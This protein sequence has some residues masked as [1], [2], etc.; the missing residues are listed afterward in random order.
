MRPPLPAGASPRTL[1]HVPASSAPPTPPPSPSLDALERLLPPDVRAAR[2]WR[3][4]AAEPVWRGVVWGRLGR[5]D[6]AWQ[7]FDRVNLPALQPWI[8]AERGR[9]LRELGLH[10][11]AEALEW[12]ALLAATDPVDDAML[13]ISLAADAVGMGDAERARRRLAAARESLANLAGASDPLVTARLARQRLRC[14]WV[15]VEVAWLTDVPPDPGGLPI[16]DAA[17]GTPR[18]TD[19]HR[20]GSTFH[21]AK[22]L[23]FAGVVHRELRLLDAATA[24]APPALAWA[25]HLARA[26]HGLGDAEVA[27]RRAWSV[28]R[29]PAAYAAQVRAGPTARRM[30]S[31]P[32]PGPR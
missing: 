15:A 5:G 30:A 1:A 8:A 7:H 6:L 24:L 17:S 31:R 16:W 4:E 10:A 3:H 11:A 26:D 21:T 13:R 22:G 20:W 32:A 19:D 14:T 23:L 9:I 28:V 25:V 12:P 27:A 18:L 2:T 29:P